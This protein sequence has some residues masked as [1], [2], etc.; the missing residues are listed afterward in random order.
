MGQWICGS[1]A[2]ISGQHP[3]LELEN[4]SGAQISGRVAGQCA[5]LLCQNYTISLQ[6]KTKKLDFFHFFFFPSL[7][8]LRFL[9][10]SLFK[11]PNFGW[12]SV[13]IFNWHCRRPSST[14]VVGC[15]SRWLDFGNFPK[16]SEM[17]PLISWA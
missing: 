5:D 13:K 4:G 15:C 11:N 17:L 10:F 2:Q 7:S 1:G 16:S 6:Y 8:S 12:M 14:T 3:D 9:S